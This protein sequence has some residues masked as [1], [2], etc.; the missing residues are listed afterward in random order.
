M[1]WESPAA[2]DNDRLG[3]GRREADAADPLGVALLGGAS[4]DSEL[5]IA[6]GVPQ[7]DGLHSEIGGVRM[8]E[9]SAREMQIEM[10]GCQCCTL[11][12]EPEMI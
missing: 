7:L 9:T 10:V 11:S 3:S 6:K 1:G 2:G 8:R 12:R 5:A 4:S